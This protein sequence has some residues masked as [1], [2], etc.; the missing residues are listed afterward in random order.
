MDLKIAECFGCVIVKR[1]EK[2]FIQYDSG[3]IASWIVENEIS[4]S[5]VEKAQMSE[6][7]AYEVII[8]A[9]GECTPRRV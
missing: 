1:N 9:Q 6:Q 4:L 5:D 3:G 2:Y 7:S 8:G